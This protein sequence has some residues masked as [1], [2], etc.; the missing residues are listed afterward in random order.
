MKQ[1]QQRT[2]MYVGN[3]LTTFAQLPDK[4]R[5]LAVFKEQAL[6]ATAQE[7]ADL[8]KTLQHKG[9]QVFHVC[10]DVSRDKAQLDR[11]ML[12]EAAR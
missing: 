8:Y 6:R 1:E 7:I 5:E 11:H 9:R 12:K 4:S 3:D 10:P 2:E